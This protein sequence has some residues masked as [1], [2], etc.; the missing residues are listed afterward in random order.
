LRYDHS[1]A[2][3]GARDSLTVAYE[4]SYALS[5]ISAELGYEIDDNGDGGWIGSVDYFYQLQTGD[6]Q[7][8]LSRE[9]TTSD[10]NQD[11]FTTQVSADWRHTLTEVSSIALRAVYAEVEYVSANIATRG[12]GQLSASYSQ[13]I[14][15][16]WSVTAGLGQ[17]RGI[18]SGLEDAVSNFV[19]VR[20][21]REFSFRP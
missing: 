9:I 11:R 14:N 17:R 7:L 21:N 2:A 15:R 19:F 13:Q 4:Q 3:T 5:R 12:R 6:I 1:I 10:N 16:D 20:L 18:Q 8:S